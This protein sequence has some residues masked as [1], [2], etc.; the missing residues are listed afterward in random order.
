MSISN[1][2]NPYQTAKNEQVIESSNAY[3]NS[4]NS[5]D[6]KKSTA[7]Q[8]NIPNGSQRCDQSLHHQ[9]QTRSSAYH[10]ATHSATVMLNTI[11]FESETPKR[12]LGLL[13]LMVAVFE[14]NGEH[15]GFRRFDFHLL[16]QRRPGCPRAT[17]TPAVHPRRSSCSAG[18]HGV[19]SIGPWLPPAQTN[20][21]VVK[22]YEP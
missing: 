11:A 17:Q 1:T 12:S 19:Q 4:Q 18:T 2:N 20:Y 15:V 6:N 14:A 13:T 16:M 5:K 10:P 3:L 7:D 9:F 21:C 8:D 22:P